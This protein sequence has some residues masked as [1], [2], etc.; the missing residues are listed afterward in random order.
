MV[1]ENQNVFVDWTLAK[2]DLAIT[3]CRPLTLAKGDLSITYCRPHTLAK[4]GLSITYCRPHTL[5]KE[6]LCETNITHCYTVQM[7]TQLTHVD[8][9]LQD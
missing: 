3:Y 1:I 7:L 6:D 9:G 8:T 5:A 2:G 4:G